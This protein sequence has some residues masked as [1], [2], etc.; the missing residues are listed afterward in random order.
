MSR[1]SRVED[2]QHVINLPRRIVVGSGVLSRAGEHFKHVTGEGAGVLV[3]TGPRVRNI[4]Y[5]RL[6]ESLEDEGYTVWPR[7]IT[8]ASVDTAEEVA[9]EAKRDRIDVIAGLGGGKAIDIAKYAAWESGKVFI[10]IPTVASHDGIT[11]PFASLKGFD[12]PVSRPAKTP[13][14]I[15]MEV[16]VIASAPRRYNIAGFGDVIGKYT[17]V[18][19]WRLASRLRGEYY[20]GYAASLALMSVRHVSQHVDEIAAGTQEG[21]RIL[22]E[23]LVSSGVAMCI[24]GSTR[25]ASGSEHLFAHALTMLAKNPPLHGELVGVGTI[26]MSYLHGRNWRKVKRILQRV[27]APTTAKELGVPEDLIIEALV[28]AASVR[29]E[30][31]TILG[32]KG[33]TPEAAEKLARVTGVIS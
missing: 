9:E 2:S 14:L 8:G 7:I 31:Y 15:L 26:M 10:S 12:K 25:P 21:W 24:A 13:A 28:K 30:R 33:I 6:A 19:D 20:G 22:L 1:A 32:E 5:P 11:S 27:G 23:A 4:V 29:P 17:A 18:L 16:S 3:V